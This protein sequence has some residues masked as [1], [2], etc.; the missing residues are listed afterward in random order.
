MDV[1]VISAESHAWPSTAGPMAALT[2]DRIRSVSATSAWAE[3]CFPICCLNCRCRGGSVECIMRRGRVGGVKHGDRSSALGGECL[4]FR[5]DS[6]HVGLAGHCPEALSALTLM[7]KDGD[8]ARS[9]CQARWASPLVYRSISTRS[10]SSSGTREPA[11]GLDILMLFLSGKSRRFR[12]LP[13]GG[14][15]ASD[16]TPHRVRPP[17]AVRRGFR[18]R[19]SGLRRRPGSGRHRESWTDGA[20]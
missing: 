20:R 7:P 15:T 5:E 14:R 16:T 19:G 13:T 8:S 11:D 9:F 4:V 18:V 2:N 12:C 1:R 10:I 17:P 3:K 6:A